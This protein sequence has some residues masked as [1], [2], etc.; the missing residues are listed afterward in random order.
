MIRFVPKLSAR[1]RSAKP[2]LDLDCGLLVFD[3]GEWR[4]QGAES[5]GGSG[6]GSAKEVGQLRRRV[7]VGAS[8]SQR[9]PLASIVAGWVVRALTWRRCAQALEE[10]NN[11]LRYKMEVLIDMVSPHPSTPHPRT[12]TAVFSHCYG[13]R[14]LFSC[15][16]MLT[17]WHVGKR[18]LA[19][20][21]LDR[22]KAEDKLERRGK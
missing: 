21:E 19:V 20:A 13:S 2:Q 9:G 11:M 14:A 18:Q 15:A 10:E 1:V 7:K 3:A 5:G 17:S 12:S 4:L 6:Q 22:K 8:R 16:G